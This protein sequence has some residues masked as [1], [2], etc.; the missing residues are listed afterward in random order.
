MSKP[1]DLPAIPHSADP[2]IKALKEALEVRLGRR[3]DTL[4]RAVTVRDLYEGGVINLIGMPVLPVVGGGGLPIS[5]RPI[6]GDTSQPPAPSN[7]VVAGAFVGILVNWARP[8]RRDLTAHIYRNTTDSQSTAVLVGISKGQVFSDAVNYGST[9]Y[10]WVRFVSAAE[11]TGPFNALAGTIGITS[12]S[13]STVIDDLGDAI[14]ETQLSTSLSTKIDNIAVNGV[15]ITTEVSDRI[16]AIN[17][18][19]SARATGDGILQGNI[20]TVSAAVT[21]NSGD[22]TGNAAAVAALV[23]R[24]TDN[25]GDITASASDI[26]ALQSSLT[27]TNTDV[28]AN[29]S[30]L[31]NL[32][33]TVTSQ[34][35]AITAS[36]SDITTL[37]TTV[38]GNSSSIQTNATTI[39]GISAEQ[40]VKIDVNGNVAGYGVYGTSTFNEFAVNADIF[41]IA[42]GS[43]GVAP[44]TVVTGAGLTTAANG[45]LYGNTTK[46]WQTTN[47]PTGKWFAA[48][49][50]ISSAMIADASIDVAKIHNLTVDM[51]QVTGTLTA[52][53]FAAI[54][55]DATEIS[56]GFLSADRIDTSLL[57]VAN[58]F[59]NGTLN[60]HNSTGAIA[61]GKTSGDDFTNTGLYFGRTGGQLRFNMGSSTSYIYFDGTTV[62]SVGT[63]SVAVAPA[64]TTQYQSPGTYTR[65][66]IGADVNRT[67]T[68][69]ILG[70][71]GGGGGGLGSAAGAGSSTT[72]RVKTQ[73]GSTRATYTAGGGQ[74][75][76]AGDWGGQN[77]W[78]N[79]SPYT[80]WSS[81]GGPVNDYGGLGQ[82]VNQGGIFVGSGGGTSRRHGS[83]ASGNGAGG[84]GFG[85]FFDNNSSA[86]GAAG[87]YATYSVAVASTTD[88]IEITVGGGGGGSTKN[89]GQ[90]DYKSGGS[91]ASG[92]AQINLA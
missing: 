71:G 38:A 65:P 25:E 89:Y 50:Y 66:L 69:K 79:K 81:N 21:T 72:V 42:N 31:S 51:A 34:G 16:A 48:G 83:N 27:N 26:T 47:H 19:V 14:G 41:K 30:G 76:P 17:A 28:T 61:W 9:Y 2:S 75:G 12:V 55:I 6:I 91:G 85:D 68:I 87:V 23:V 11:V 8:Q 33:T 49:T 4:D 78:W 58:M 18:E 3:G 60:V 36:A 86:S 15:S 80:T 63:Q 45:T 56:S 59:L 1:T 54:T 77:G 84:G 74:G 22:I 88:Y 13:V 20:D 40:F 67:I 35:S 73:S 64:A 39:N 82:P 24:V 29:A 62:Q 90:G 32:T 46:S 70:G 52:A 10:Y 7:V 37:N 53:Q 57:N 43:S 44:F 92:A 5:P